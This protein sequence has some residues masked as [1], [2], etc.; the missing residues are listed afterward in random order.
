VYVLVPL[1]LLFDQKL[2]FLNAF[3]VSFIGNPLFILFCESHSGLVSL[4]LSLHFLDGDKDFQLFEICTREVDVYYLVIWVI[5]KDLILQVVPKQSFQ[6]LERFVFLVF[7]EV[8]YAHC[9]IFC[10]HML[11]I[12]FFVL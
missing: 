6:L 5:T 1:L 11:L 7:G 4:E 8:F 9:E 10:Q 2:V 3:Q 12:V